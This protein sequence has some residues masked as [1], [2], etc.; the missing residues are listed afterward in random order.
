L[1]NEYVNLDQFIQQNRLPDVFVESAERCYLP[2]AEWLDVEVAEK[3]GESYVLGINGAQGTGK[4]TLAHLISEYLTS[5]HERKVVVLSID[6]IYL[7]RDERSSLGRRIHPLLKTRGVP[8][9]HDVSLGISVIEQLRSLQQ[10]ET[11]DI[12]AFDKSRDDRCAPADWTTVTGPVDLVIFEGWCVASRATT[13]AELQDPI[14]ALE[15]SADA[16]GR[17]RAYV[18]DKLETDYVQ[19]FAALD[20]LLFLQVP[21][22]EAVF[23]W[24][25]EQEQKLRRSTNKDVNGIMTD[26]QVAGFIQFFERITRNNI[27]VLPSVAD[28]VI[29]FGDD[30]QAI[31]LSFPNC[32]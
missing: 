32:A 20:G 3:L 14:N 5:E 26:E 30:H 10:G 28:A 4:S 22:F 19:L 27:S 8:G 31:S 15:S 21:D 18:N 2:F 25:L 9:T 17:W 13:S 16:E 23:R 6:D 1:V 12:P 24:R 7:T 11:M 29:K